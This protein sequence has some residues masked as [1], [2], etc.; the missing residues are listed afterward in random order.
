[1]IGC[2]GMHAND[3]AKCLERLLPSEEVALVARRSCTAREVD[4]RPTAA[5]ADTN[6]SL[7][8]APRA[9]NAECLAGAKLN[10]IR[11]TTAAEFIPALSMAFPD[12]L[13]ECC[14]QVRPLRI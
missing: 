3:T 11:K 14:V 8:A 7:R 1:M 5:K 10:Q 13:E 12:I 6:P 9:W 4:A 2:S